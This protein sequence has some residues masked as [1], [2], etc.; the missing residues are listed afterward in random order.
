MLQQILKEMYIDPDVLEALNEE[1]K[2]ILFLKMRQ[3]QVRRWTEREENFEKERECLNSQKPK[4]ASTKS[5]SWLLG[6]DGDVHVCVIGEMAGVKP[7]DLIC[8][9][10]DD[11]RKI[12]NDNTR[13]P[14]S[15][16][17]QKT[18]RQINTPQEDGIQLN[19]QTAE[20]E[21]DTA[22]TITELKDSGLYYRSHLQHKEPQSLALRLWNR[23]HQEEKA[24]RDFK[25]VPAA[26]RPVLS[27]DS[28]EANQSPD[29]PMAQGRVAELRKNFNHLQVT[30]GKNTLSRVKPPLPA[31]P[32]TFQLIS[33]AGFR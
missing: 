33:S 15:E 4:Q 28:E 31:K 19:F 12:N 25:I 29:N 13:A 22:D 21:K 14:V 16:T 6:K 17:F 27:S 26:R 30:S 32:T 5:V 1:Q 7:Y 8:S 20:K 3:E 23:D 18:E 2:K 9:Q 24:G 11:K 10:I